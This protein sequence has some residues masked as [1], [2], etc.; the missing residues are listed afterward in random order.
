[1]AVTVP[2]PYF[3]FLNIRSIRWVTTKPPKI[4][5]DANMTA[6]KPSKC[7]KLIALLFVLPAAEIVSEPTAIRAPTIMIPEIALVTDIRG[8]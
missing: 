6:K 5:I 1:M 7:E 8:V 4:F 2:N 3:F